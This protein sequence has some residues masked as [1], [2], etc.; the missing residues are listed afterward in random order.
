MIFLFFN[1]FSEPGH[2]DRILCEGILS[3]E[4]R[5]GLKN[6]FLH[7]PEVSLRAKKNDSHQYA[8]NNNAKNFLEQFAL[9]FLNKDRL[10]DQ[11]IKIMSSIGNNFIAPN[12][13]KCKHVLDYFNYLYSKSMNQK[14]TLDNYDDYKKI[15]L[16]N[17]PINNFSEDEI[18][19]AFS[20]ITDKENVFF[21]KKIIRIIHLF[22]KGLNKK[23]IDFFINITQIPK[24]VLDE[25]SSK[26]Y[27]SKFLIKPDN[28][29]Q[30]LL[31]VGSIA[32]KRLG[33]NKR[34]EKRTYSSARKRIVSFFIN[35]M[36]NDKGI[37]DHNFKNNLNNSESYQ[38]WLVNKL[39]KGKKDALEFYNLF[40]SEALQAIK[41]E[42][43]K[44]KA[45]GDKTLISKFIVQK[46]VDNKISIQ[47]DWD[48]G[49][50]LANLSMP[51]KTVLEDKYLIIS[52]IFFKEMKA[53]SSGNR[54][55][56]SFLV[57]MKQELEDLRKK[58]NQQK[59]AEL[60][61]KK[62]KL[63]EKN[64]QLKEVKE[65]KDKNKKTTDGYFNSLNEKYDF[66]KM[67]LEVHNKRSIGRWDYFIKSFEAYSK[68]NFLDK[69]YKIEKLK[70]TSRIDTM[71][72]H[73]KMSLKNELEALG[74]TKAIL[75]DEI[76]L[77]EFMYKNLS[78]IDKHY[79][80][81]IFSSENVDKLFQ[82]L[83]SRYM[84]EGKEAKR[85]FFFEQVLQV[86]Q[87]SNQ[88]KATSEIELPNLTSMKNSKTLNSPDKK[89]FIR[90]FF[91]GIYDYLSDFDKKSNI[92]IEDMCNFVE[93]FKYRDDCLGDS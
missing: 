62:K 75:E 9:Q 32:D 77:N 40:D 28:I 27:L 3:P 59:K 45:Y 70:Y 51:E 23:I 85:Q 41:N 61:K 89:R 83:K 26:E 13:Q 12:D 82:A 4:S 14:L 74:L 88:E 2:Q 31:P 52:Y 79:I 84:H 39:F 10:D 48:I 20:V 6:W 64:N 55:G 8:F 73:K 54:D 69:K 1:V 15:F 36:I 50:Y 78:K 93:K 80:K 24:I 92:S 42:L 86:I 66:I 22:E 43:K 17:I 5:T 72:L 11:L 16:T 67:I 71:P 35:L 30:G 34:V 21:L 58:N 87:P 76:L 53:K 37:F 91:K 7:E 57:F 47:S 46:A 33:P 44:F 68:K 90:M 19:K 81:N 65:V 25:K 56:N 29:S 63:I 18:D 38:E 49:T 60:A